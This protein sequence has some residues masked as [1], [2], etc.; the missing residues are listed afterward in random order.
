[1][2]YNN[3]IYFLV[4]I[5]LLSTDNAPVTPSL[6][7]M[8]SLPLFAAIYLVYFQVCRRIF[9]RAGGGGSRAYFAAEKKLSLLA[10]VFFAA[11][12]Y[13]LDLK[14]YLHPFSFD[15]H[16]P[17]LENLGGLLLFFGFL[18]LMWIQARDYYQAVF[19]REHSLFSFILT[20]IRAN[21]PIIAPWVV[22]SFLFDLL[23]LL[24]IPWLKR[25]MDSPWGDVGLFGLFI[26]FLLFFFP[27]LVRVLWS[28]TPL[29][30]GYLRRKMEHFCREQGFTAEILVWPLFEGQVITAGVMG[31]V[32][33]LRYLLVTPALLNAMSWEELQSVLAH[34]IGHVKKKHL[35]LYI[36]LFFGF[37]LFAGALAEP[38]PYFVL[39]SEWLYQ[40]TDLLR[41]S[42]EVLV[43]ILVA[44]PLLLLMI[45]YFRYLFG[46]F[47]RNFERQADLYVF[48]ALGGSTALIS[49]FEKIA[50]LGGNIRDQ[51]SW[52]HFGIG[53][54][55]DFLEKCEQDRSRIRKQDRKLILSLVAY[56]VVVAGCVWGLGRLDYG[57]MTAGFEMRY[58]EA[59]LQYKLREDPEN[60]LLFLVLGDLM[61]QKRLEAKAIT[62]YENALALKPMNPEV[63]N[64]LAW[65]LLTAHDPLLRDP[66]RALQL[67]RKAADIKEAGYILDTLA[68][69]FWA[70]MKVEQALAAERRAAAIDPINRDYYRRQLEKI[71]GRSWDAGT[72]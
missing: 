55:I 61:Q 56:F 47:I 35:L 3:L 39:S 23:A 58:V 1:M 42:P 59:V 34:E 4:V 33:G 54:R 12:L 71:G 36:S 5:F 38:L 32:P 20:N 45:L 43:A 11:S 67:A 28:C 46:Y 68:V 6:P 24:D 57:S 22:L 14:Y 51:K 2:I 8:L 52:H 15:G 26:L 49:S 27:P 64:N 9:S 13:G 10:V 60:G 17:V 25:V 66:A 65:L 69:A 62:A 70:N 29:P 16:F 37:S 63:L 31:I 72:P 7:P 18:C 48:K 50:V 41:F 19:L 30:G 21:L 44:A 40:L 53:E